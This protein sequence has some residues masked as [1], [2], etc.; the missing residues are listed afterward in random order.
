M[1]TGRAGGDR[2]GTVAG[3]EAS[4][5]VAPDP[6]RPYDRRCEHLTGVARPAG[7][8]GAGCAEC[9]VLGWAWSR[10]RWCTTC[11]HVGCCDSSRGRHSH[12]HHAATGHPVVLSID[13]GEDWGWCYVDELFLVAPPPEEGAP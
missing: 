12:A 7:P 8:V 11:G 5:T 10:L 2:K 1:V 3:S 13:P 9:L 4:W 6:G